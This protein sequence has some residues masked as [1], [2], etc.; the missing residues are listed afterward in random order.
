M[1]QNVD[2]RSIN[3]H[4]ARANVQYELGIITSLKQHLTD[5][6]KECFLIQ[7][8]ITFYHNCLSLCDNLR[9][10]MHCYMRRY[11]FLSE[12]FGYIQVVMYRIENLYLKQIFYSKMRELTD[13]TRANNM[14]MEHNLRKY[15]DSLREQFEFEF[16]Y[17]E[18]VAL[19]DEYYAEVNFENNNLKYIID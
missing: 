1:N 2:L 4:I 19:H 17:P 16:T 18:I 14:L 10:K 5:E 11:T 15:K 7:K 3:F 12:I 9:Y 13:L 6:E 8:K